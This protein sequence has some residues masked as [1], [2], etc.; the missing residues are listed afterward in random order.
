MLDYN[1]HSDHREHSGGNVIFLLLEPLMMD[2]WSWILGQV[3][4]HVV[5]ERREREREVPHV[6][7]FRPYTGQSYKLHFNFLD[8]FVC[9]SYGDVQR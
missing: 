1:R 5:L 6:H 3:F 8:L 9:W 2:C 7:S 4:R